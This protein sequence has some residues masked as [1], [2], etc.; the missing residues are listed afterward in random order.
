MLESW[1]QLL[2]KPINTS[3]YDLAMQHYRSLKDKMLDQITQSAKV[4]M[5]QQGYNAFIDNVENLILQNASDWGEGY[6]AADTTL[7][8]IENAVAEIIE[9]GQVT[10]VKTLLEEI[11]KEIDEKESELKDAQQTFKSK[12]NANKNAIFTKLSIDNKFI[13]RMLDLTNTS[14]DTSDIVAQ[15][16]S[17]FIRYLYANLFDEKSFA[18]RSRFKYAMSLG[19]YYKEL[20]EYEALEK[21]LN[22][23]ISVHHA[24]G[25]KI[26]GKD[27]EMDIVITTLQDLKTGLTQSVTLNETISALQEPPGAQDLMANLIEQIETFGEQVKSKRLGAS[28]QFEI[29][30]RATLYSQFL[31]EGGN[32]YSSLQALHFLARYKN[33]ILSL[34]AQNVLFSSN[35]KR[36][37]MVDFIEDFRRQAYLLAFMRDNNKSPLS[38]KVGLEQLYTKS[39]SAIK[40]RFMS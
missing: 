30:N 32:Q 35:G 22:N 23:F 15:A 28:D 9:S 3:G 31:S 29:G 26:K 24:G 1:Q 34:G 12:L 19:G 10:E 37:W 5:T 38:E 16:S 27:T 2:N 39:R 36:Q 20:H 33:I 18:E 7:N 40:S 13:E 25:T 4:Q 21:I 6:K 11:R 17:Y 14:G 8:K